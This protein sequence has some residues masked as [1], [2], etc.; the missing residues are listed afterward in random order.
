MLYLNYLNCDTQYVVQQDKTPLGDHIFKINNLNFAIKKEKA[1]LDDKI[2]NK[3]L[4]APDIFFEGIYH[5][6]LFLY[7]I[8]TIENQ[9]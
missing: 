9:S 5:N 3:F 6:M 8:L 7:H 1:V 2:I 4:P